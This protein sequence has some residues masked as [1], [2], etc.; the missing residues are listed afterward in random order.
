MMTLGKRRRNN[1]VDYDSVMLYVKEN[2]DCTSLDLA[3]DFGVTIAR[4]FTFMNLLEKQGLIFKTRVKSPTNNKRIFSYRV[5]PGF[6]EISDNG[7]RSIKPAFVVRMIRRIRQHR[8][9]K[10]ALMYL[11]A[12]NS[13]RVANGIPIIPES[14]LGD[15]H[16]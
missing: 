7:D 2:P 3:R 10:I 13:W 16:A 12:H 9:P 6:D 1:S 8:G 5:I 4:A 14:S 11:D 15:Y